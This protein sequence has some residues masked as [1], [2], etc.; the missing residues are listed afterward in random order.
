MTFAER[1]SGRVF[2]LVGAVFAVAY[3]AAFARAPDR[4][5]P[6]NGDAIQYYAYLRSAV[7]DHDLDFTN[8][9]THG[10]PALG[11]LPLLVHRAQLRGAHLASPVRPG[12]PWAAGVAILWAPTFLIAHPDGSGEPFAPVND[13]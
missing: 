13:S 8:D 9:Y 3:V 6:I 5:R 11:T 7:F 1:S 4:M 12:N 2:V 10:G